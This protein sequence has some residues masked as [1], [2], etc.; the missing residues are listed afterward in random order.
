MENLVTAERSELIRGFRQHSSGA[1]VRSRLGIAAFVVVAT[2]FLWASFTGGIAQGQAGKIVFSSNRGGESFQIYIMDA[3]GTNIRP[4]TS[5]GRNDAPRFSPDGRRIVFSAARDGTAGNI[6]SASI[7]V[8]NVDGT[9]EIRLTNPYSLPN[10]PVAARA[11]DLTARF[12]HD[13]TKIIF[14]SRRETSLTCCGGK[15][16]NAQIYLMGTAGENMVRLTAFDGGPVYSRSAFWP[17]F[18]PD[19]AKI[20]FAGEDG[21]AH[22]EIYVMNADGTNII[23]LTSNRLTA[24]MPVFSPDGKAIAFAMGR[25]GFPYDADI[26]LMNADGSQ[27]VRLTN[28]EGEFWPAFSPDGR[29]ILFSSARGAALYV[30]N[31]DGTGQTRLTNP[32]KGKSCCADWKADWAIVAP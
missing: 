30:M 27:Q 12:N 28:S 5:S 29:R 3:D 10:D 6:G 19:G 22:T 16:V 23:R 20:V 7:Y 8:M 9:G 17:A 2:T 11:S 32:P 25:R 4:L 24:D 26:Y 15:R 21:E 31:T 14:T 18:S 13:G 1:V